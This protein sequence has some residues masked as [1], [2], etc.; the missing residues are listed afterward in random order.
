VQATTHHTTPT[1]PGRCLHTTDYHTLA[2]RWLPRP[3]RTT[4]LAGVPYLTAYPTTP[5]T[6]RDLHGCYGR[7]PATTTTP[8]PPACLLH[9]PGR[10]PILPGS[11][12]TT[13]H[14]Q[15][16]PDHACHTT[17]RRHHTTTVPRHPAT[18]LQFLPRPLPAVDDLFCPTAWVMPGSSLE[19]ALGRRPSRRP[20]RKNYEQLRRFCA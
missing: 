19:Q 20:R 17:A 13:H 18:C 10:L 12:P 2:L 9:L 6:C 4:Q 15:D 5:P 1:N 8:P 3:P 16:L 11:C 7:L 14:L